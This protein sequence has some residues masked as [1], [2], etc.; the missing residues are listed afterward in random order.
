MPA[1]SLLL[2]CEAFEM[3]VVG[4]L[5]AVLT[6]SRDLRWSLLDTLM[7]WATCFESKLP[8]DTRPAEVDLWLEDRLEGLL[9][10]DSLARD[11]LGEI[12]MR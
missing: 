11:R 7:A 1:R 5:M 8:M 6:I 4:W 3:F 2:A 10:L 12:D 9:P